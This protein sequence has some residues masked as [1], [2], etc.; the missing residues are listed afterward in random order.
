MC[1][2]VTE[3][4]ETDLLIS[5]ILAIKRGDQYMIENLAKLGAPVG[6]L[7]VMLMAFKMADRDIVTFLLDLADRNISSYRKNGKSPLILFVEENNI[8]AVKCLLNSKHFTE[9]EIDFQS[10]DDPCNETALHKA[11]KNNQEK[12]VEQLLL[13][14][15]NLLLRDVN[16]YCPI[17]VAALTGNVEIVEQLL[18][19]NM[20]QADYPVNL[21]DNL[22]HVK[23]YH[24]AVWKEDADVIELLERLG[25]SP[26]CTDDDQKKSP[27][28]FAIQEERCQIVM[29][30]ADIS[31]KH[32]V[33]NMSDHRGNTALHIAIEKLPYLKDPKES[34]VYKE[35]ISFLCQTGINVFT[36]NLEGKSA[37]ML[38]EESKQFD[39]MSK[40]ERY[41]FSSSSLSQET[42]TEQNASE[43]DDASPT[44][45]KRVKHA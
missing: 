8:E 33:H 39:V 1:S 3:V 40:L 35:V 36:A 14:N 22:K 20:K 45:A 11:C 9:N 6:D 5:M 42:E 12:I 21:S 27:L 23:L 16:G 4:L 17:H 29:K 38:A 7:N 43:C 25:I 19:H 31:V 41:K 32:E 10:E 26:G 30:L 44:P 34:E 18:K 24:I 37:L 28:M 15:P 13:A 2:S